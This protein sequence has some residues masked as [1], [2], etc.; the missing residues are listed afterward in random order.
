MIDSMKISKDT[1]EKFYETELFP[2]YGDSPMSLDYGDEGSQRARFIIVQE[3][4]IKS[5]D[6]V[7]DVACGLGH[8]ADYLFEN[9]I[10]VRYT[11]HDISQIFIDAARK[12][13]ESSN[14]AKENVR[15]EVK[16]IFSNAIT[17]TYDW[18]VCISFNLLDMAIIKKLF[19]QS[20]KGVAITSLSRYGEKKSGDRAPQMM[21][22]FRDQISYFSKCK[23]NVTPW[24]VLRHDYLNHDFAIYLF[25]NP[26]F[27][28]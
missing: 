9:K 4:G 5:G 20:K 2:K 25:R 24:V 11:G 22:P 19:K 8:F 7:L 12:R 26:H 17:S 23:K 28:G 1:Y 15:F 13:Y 10:N 3:I 14:S 6:S 18:V 27:S 16:D 21:F